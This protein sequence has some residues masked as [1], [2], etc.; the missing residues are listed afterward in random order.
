MERKRLPYADVVQ[1]I[2]FYIRYFKYEWHIPF[3]FFHKYVAPNDSDFEH[4]LLD[5]KKKALFSRQYKIFE[6]KI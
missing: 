4:G 1:K 5:L 2:T 3:L 6:L